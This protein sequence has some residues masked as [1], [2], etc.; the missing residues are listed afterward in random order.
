M[1]ELVG[2]RTGQIDPSTPGARV[3]AKD[4]KHLLSARQRHCNDQ[5]QHDCRQ[6]L[7]FI[8]DGRTNNF[9]GYP[10][11]TTYWRDGLLLEPEAVP[12][13]ENYLRTHRA[14]LEAGIDRKDWR[15]IPFDQAVKL[16]R[17]GGDRKS[18]K[19]K[20]QGDNVTLK[21][22]GNSRAYI[23][24][25]LARDYPDILERYERGEFKSAR[26]AGLAAGIVKR[27]RCPHCG[28]EL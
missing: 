13:A 12:F 20:D 28:G 27:R 7:F 16:G 25:R 22:R 10:D 14:R 1:V 4:W 19:I 5:F 6:L 26:A 9:F 11:E 3:A 17:H 24:A 18:E 15:E 2:I 21:E 8:D 23:L